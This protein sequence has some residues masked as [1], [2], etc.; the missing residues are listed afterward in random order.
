MRLFTKEAW[1]ADEVSTRNCFNA[2]FKTPNCVRC[3]KGHS[4]P[5]TYNSVVRSDKLMPECIG[6]RQFDND[7]G[8]AN[9]QQEAS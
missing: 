8:T 3:A 7:W 9:G 6:C 4:I 1:P 5:S 2:K